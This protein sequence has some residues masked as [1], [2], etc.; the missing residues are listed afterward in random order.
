MNKRQLQ[1]FLDVMET[2]SIK[3]SAEKNMIS[4][5]GLSK[6]IKDL[7]KE[8]NVTL[9]TRSSH[10]LNP[11]IHAIS[12]KHSA[13]I[14]I[15]EYENIHL[16]LFLQKKESLTT[17]RVLSTYGMLKYLTMDFIVDFYAS[18]PLIRLNIVEYPDNPIISMLREEQIELA[19]LPAPIDNTGFDASYC[20]THNHCLII[21]K[22]N[23]L[24]KKAEIEY[25][26]LKNV[27]LA[28]KGREYIPYS[29]N[30]NRFLKNGVTPDIMLET[31]DD[32]LIHEIAKRNLGIGVSLDCIA[33]DDLN[34][35][36]VMRP[37]ADKNN[38]K[39]VF[40]VTK[41]GKNLSKEALAFRNFTQDWLGSHRSQLFKW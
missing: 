30:I 13:D 28:I 36:I 34:D 17:L 5:Q 9:F 37:F 24:S 27:P 14:I 39:D 4:S 16:N 3:K 11:T 20:S 7:E 8:L 29:N 31:S 6:M 40:L 32:H 25:E 19:F 22:Q 41:K 12:L 23:K 10:G 33:F 2:H 15:Q 35:D 38:V 21:N 26:D 18:N 1:Y